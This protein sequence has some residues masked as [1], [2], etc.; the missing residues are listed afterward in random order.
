MSALMKSIST[1][2]SL[3]A[4]CAVLALSPPHRANAIE[5]VV[6]F[7]HDPSFSSFP[8][9]HAA[10]NAAAAG[11]SRLITST[12]SPVQIS[13]APSFSAMSGSGLTALVLRNPEY[14]NPTTGN[15]QT[16]PGSVIPA[17]AI[18]VYFGAQPLAGNTLAQS[19]RR[20]PFRSLSTSAFGPDEE[21]NAA[22]VD[23][24]AQH[25]AV[26]GRGAPLVQ[27]TFDL[28]GTTIFPTAPPS[29]L[30]QGPAFGAIWFDNDANNDMA[31]DGDAEL[32]A[33]WHFDYSQPAAPEKVDFYTVALHE[34]MHIVTNPRIREL[35]GPGDEWLG[36][37]ARALNGGAG[38][39][40]IEPGNPTHL[41]QDLLS[42]RLSDGQ[43]QFTAL[44]QLTPGSGRRE[45]T[46]MDLAIL[47]DIGWAVVP[48]PPAPTLLAALI[49]A[50]AAG[51]NLSGRA[52]ACGR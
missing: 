32:S 16:Y 1:R 48:E 23:L 31:I 30:K 21:R 8:A 35:V 17:D 40:I 50:M 13:P 24:V 26:M 29:V 6:D 11:L 42:P 9:A 34:L 41:R 18:I 39:G 10:V 27:A 36:P 37:A 33:A 4:A 49:A 46:R 38:F 52:I 44:A 22:L 25:N 15:L 3:L 28:G 7:T 19:A 45:M 43:P 12:L 5:L 14:L 20:A 51:A 47:E 2:F